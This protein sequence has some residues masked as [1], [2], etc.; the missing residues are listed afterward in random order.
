MSAQV[1]K[2]PSGKPATPALKRSMTALEKELLEKYGE[3]QKERLDRG[4]KQVA[5]F[6]RAED[7][8]AKAFEEFVGANFAGDPAT[9]DALFKRMEFAMESLDGH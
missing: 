4:M 9:L 1:K 6:W 3:G 5:G 2:P 8:D 7:G